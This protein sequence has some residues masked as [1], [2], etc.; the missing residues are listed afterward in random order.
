MYFEIEGYEL[1]CTNR[2]NKRGGGTAFFVNRRLKY[3]IITNTTIAI[4]DVCECITIKIDMEKKK[5]IIISC[6]YRAPS[7][8]IEHFKNAMEGLFTNTEQ[9]VTFICGDFNIDLL[10]PNKI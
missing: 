7:S 4:D 1:N 2:V 6:V 10:N 5:K 8:S 3:K 9:K